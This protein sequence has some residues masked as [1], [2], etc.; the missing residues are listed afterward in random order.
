[1]LYTVIR[2]KRLIKKIICIVLILFNKPYQNDP[3]VKIQRKY[4][5]HEVSTLNG[6]NMSG[7]LSKKKKNIKKNIKK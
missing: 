3:N 1:M 7:A 2:C 5:K 6:T 4:R